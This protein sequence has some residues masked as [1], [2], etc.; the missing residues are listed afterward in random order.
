MI[1]LI[2]LN[3]TK[4]FFPFI[5]PYGFQ[6]LLIQ[7]LYP[8][9]MPTAPHSVVWYGLHLRLLFS[10]C[11]YSTVPA[12]ITFCV[13]LFNIFSV[14]GLAVTEPRFSSIMML[15]FLY[16]FRYVTSFFLHYF[17]AKSST[18]FSICIAFQ[19]ILMIFIS[20]IV[21]SS[22]LGV[23]VIFHFCNI[24]LDIQRTHISRLCL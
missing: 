24:C 14:S 7:L 19:L 4:H 15:Q 3:L 5:V 9:H 1:I 20:N 16:L 23:F 11:R 12:T 8:Y 21:N 6:T 10:T 18:Q 17:N 22:S 2:L 13:L